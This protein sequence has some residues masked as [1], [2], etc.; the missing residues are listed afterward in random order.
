[1][2]D[3]D[4]GDEIAT[5]T[6]AATTVFR[7]VPDE[8]LDQPMADP[9]EVI[10]A[11]LPPGSAVL[12]V[13]RGPGAGAR[14]ALLKSVTTVGRHPESDIALDDVTV[15]RSHAELHR[16]DHHVL[17]VDTRSVNGVYVNRAAVHTASLRHGDEVWIGK[18]RLM[19]LAA[20][21]RGL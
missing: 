13:L 10:A 8:Q 2:S 4:G 12:V 18:V 16:V 19:F 15:S 5:S 14:F 9:L 17:I 6:G 7:Q 21:A 1:V 3:R 20:A 11:R